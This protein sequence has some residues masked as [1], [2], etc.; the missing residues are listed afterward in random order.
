VN[1]VAP[2]ATATNP[3]WRS[4]LHHLVLVSG[5]ETNT[6]FSVR[7]VIRAGLTQETQKLA[8]LVP[9]YGSYPNEYVLPLN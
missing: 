1:Q 5:W 4:A 6:P 9:G 3:S 2:D 7:Q 8:A